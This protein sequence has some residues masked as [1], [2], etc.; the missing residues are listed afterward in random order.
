[1]RGILQSLIIFCL[2][3]NG[4][5][6]QSA[7]PWAKMAPGLGLDEG[8][9]ITND[10]QGN[11]Y[12]TGQF[13]SPT[14]SFGTNTLTNGAG[15]TVFLAK[16]DCNDVILWAKQAKC[17]AM[18]YGNAVTTDSQGNCYITG[19]FTSA[20]MVFGSYTLTNAGNEDVFFVKY[21]PAGNVIWA[22]SAGRHRKILQR[23]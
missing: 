13:T 21:S 14:V 19:Y 18:D 16:Y 6:A 11:V 23:P 10:P 8:I 4:L 2:F 5:N 22:K 3:L 7:F 20:S 1:M 17:T 9:A 12:V 15:S